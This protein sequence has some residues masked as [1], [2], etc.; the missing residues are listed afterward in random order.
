MN[1]T[2]W[3]LASSPRDMLCSGWKGGSG[4]LDAPSHTSGAPLTGGRGRRGAHWAT[5]LT[6]WIYHRFP[7]TLKYKGWE[8]ETIFPGIWRWKLAAGRALVFPAPVHT[9]RAPRDGEFLHCLLL[10][11]CKS[12]IGALLARQVK[13][14]SQGHP[15]V[16]GTGHPNGKPFLGWVNRSV[17]RAE[18]GGDSIHH[19]Q[20]GPLNTCLESHEHQDRKHAHHF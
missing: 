15:A 10:P 12:S 16:T 18:Q 17:R 20:A 7:A 13:A 14:H 4:L 6:K 5:P 19:T 1:T 3:P 2:L 8:R 9:H 11:L